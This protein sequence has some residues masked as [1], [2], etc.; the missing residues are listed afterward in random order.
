LIHLNVYDLVPREITQDR[1]PRDPG[2]SHEV[3]RA[4]HKQFDAIAVDLAQFGPEVLHDI[5]GLLTEFSH[6][7]PVVR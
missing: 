3:I 6:A 2:N 1:L 7:Q 5:D 4:H